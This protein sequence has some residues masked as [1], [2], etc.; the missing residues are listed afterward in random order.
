MR[1]IRAG[2][3]VE[4]GFL[5][6]TVNDQH[7]N[8]WAMRMPIASSNLQLLTPDVGVCFEVSAATGV[9]TFSRNVNVNADLYVRGRAVAIGPWIAGHFDGGPPVANVNITGQ[10]LWTVT[11]SATQTGVYVVT[12]AEPRP[13]GDSYTVLATIPA[14]GFVT[15]EKTAT[16]PT[17]SAFNT[18]ALP[19]HP[20]ELNL[21][22]VP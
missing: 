22:T 21:T 7:L 9:T 3:Q 15:W 2:N 10:C 16:S 13:K 18:S 20:A 6:G 1:S 17:F 11:R 14:G 4:A 5:W 12:F 8:R 19:T